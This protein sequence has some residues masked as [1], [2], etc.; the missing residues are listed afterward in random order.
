MSVFCYQN[1]KKCLFFI[2]TKCAAMG[3]RIVVSRSRVKVV[4]IF[5]KVVYQNVFLILLAHADTKNQTLDSCEGLKVVLV[6]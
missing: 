2:E 1:R 3:F 4:K 6:A 5:V